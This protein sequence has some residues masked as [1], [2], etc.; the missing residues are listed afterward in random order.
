MIRD[1]P[2][3]T[4]FPSSSEISQCAVDRQ[5]DWRGGAR[6]SA[7]RF[8]NTVLLSGFL[9][10]SLSPSI[11]RFADH[12]RRRPNRPS[13]EIHFLG[14]KIERSPINGVFCPSESSRVFF[15]TFP[16]INSF[17][18]A[19]DHESLWGAQKSRYSR[20]LRHAMISS[21]FKLECSSDYID[22]TFGYYAIT[23]WKMNIKPGILWY[24]HI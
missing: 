10:G 15:R 9:S 20:I 19:L 18:F 5:R 12:A 17:S 8:L 6:R 7:Y 16:S 14:R 2:S 4:N 13:A 21:R 24:G 3:A 11:P 1:A 22:L 23:A